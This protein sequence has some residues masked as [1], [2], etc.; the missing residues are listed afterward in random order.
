[1]DAKSYFEHTKGMGVLATAGSDGKVDVAVFARPHFTDNGEMAFIMPDKLTR[2][3]LLEN[4][5]AAYLFVEEGP[6]YKGKRFYLTKS[7]EE[8][9][10][11]LLY[12]L[13]RK[14]YGAAE[15]EL[16]GSKYLVFFSV[17]Q[18]L[19]LVGTGEKGAA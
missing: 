14:S 3:N 10:S 4:A 9:E 18:E 15:E 16:E 6:G 17:E 7:R 5:H 19:P 11:P 8:K 12:E 13:R 2:K 1:M